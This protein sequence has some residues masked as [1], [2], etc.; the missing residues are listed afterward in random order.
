MSRPEANRQEEVNPAPVHAPQ[1][2]VQMKA[3]RRQG[4]PHTI[5]VA[6]EVAEANAGIA[7]S[8]QELAETV[9][10]PRQCHG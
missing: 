1:S 8:T 7:E 9:R 3:L 6:P 2:T 10:H 4:R 5:D